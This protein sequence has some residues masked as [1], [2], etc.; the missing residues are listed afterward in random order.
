MMIILRPYARKFIRYLRG[1]YVVTLSEKDSEGSI[2]EKCFIDFPIFESLQ[3]ELQII[4]S[5]LLFFYMQRSS[6]IIRNRDTI[7]SHSRCNNH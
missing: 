7:L 4:C 6:I 2:N 5:S 3:N 1:T